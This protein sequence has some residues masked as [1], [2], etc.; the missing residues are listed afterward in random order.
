MSA[1]P[2]VLS[3]DDEADD[4]YVMYYRQALVESGFSVTMCAKPKKALSFVR[5]NGKDV[6]AIVLDVMMAHGP[7]FSKKETHTGLRTGELLHPRL[8]HSCNP[9]V[10]TIVLTNVGDIQGLKFTEGPKLRICRKSQT[11]PYKLRDMLRQM[12][13]TRS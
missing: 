7:E 9:D 2:H 13:H 1:I 5:K 10:I 4:R 12:L 11:P 3:V 8:L 6:S